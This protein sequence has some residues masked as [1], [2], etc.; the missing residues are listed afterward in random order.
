MANK[1][2]IAGTAFGLLG[3]ATLG[4]LSPMLKKSEGVVYVDYYDPLG[5]PTACMGHTGSDVVVG[6]KRTVAECDKLDRADINRTWN[7]MA[8]CITYKF[9]KPNE[10]AAFTSVAYN[11]GI[12]AFCGSTMLM[13]I[14][15]E[16]IAG[17]CDAIMMWDKPRNLRGIL[18]RRTNEREV[19][20]G[21]AQY[22]RPIDYSGVS[23]SNH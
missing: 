18:I 11:I 14:N 10:K 4:I 6:K 9:L 12:T 7:G 2:K 1:L 13:R 17:A 5:I 3:L 23:R 19:C 22:V 21:G 16:D 20:L 8:Q 15:A